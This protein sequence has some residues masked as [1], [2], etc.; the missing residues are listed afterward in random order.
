[1]TDHWKQPLPNI[2]HRAPSGQFR[3]IGCD[4]YEGPLADFLI[5]DYLKQNVATDA[6]KAALSPMVAVYVY[7]DQGKCLFNKFQPAEIPRKA[8]K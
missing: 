4:T 7:D 3:V 5:G 1:M 2:A 8:P 6:A